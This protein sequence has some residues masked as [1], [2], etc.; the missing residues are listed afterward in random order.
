MK[1]INLLF[2]TVFI[3]GVLNINA[4]ANIEDLEKI[5][6]EGGFEETNKA[7]DEANAFFEKNIPLPTRLPNVAFTHT[8]ARFSTL[9]YP[10]LE[11][12]FFNENFG[13]TNY[14]IYI[15]SLEYKK[16]LE[17][18]E[19]ISK[20][21]LN[22]ESEAIYLVEE[23]FSLFIFEKNKFQYTLMMDNENSESY[24]IQDLI[25]IANSI[26]S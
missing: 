10:N 23:Y 26:K 21:K 3:F 17:H 19:N 9:G 12:C 2:L 7:L 22:D 13:K 6:L 15:T 16:K 20:V 5:Y 24:K 25:K 18:K 14:K 8:F 11:I 1:K 4:N